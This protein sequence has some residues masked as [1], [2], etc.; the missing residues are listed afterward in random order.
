VTWT[1]TV[2]VR[3]AGVHAMASPQLVREAVTVV[4]PLR[5]AVKRAL[6]VPQPEPGWQPEAVGVTEGVAVPTGR[7]TATAELVGGCQ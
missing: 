4:V 6:S 7:S 5:R 1:V 2:K 3:W